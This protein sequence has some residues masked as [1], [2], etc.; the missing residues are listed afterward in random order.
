MYSDKL[1]IYSTDINADTRLYILKSRV[2]RLCRSAI[3]SGHG[4]GVCLVPLCRNPEVPQ[5]GLEV[6]G[7][8]AGT[9]PKKGPESMCLSAASAGHISSLHRPHLTFLLPFLQRAPGAFV[10]IPSK[11]SQH[12]C[13]VGKDSGP[14]RCPLGRGLGSSLPL[15]KPTAA[16]LGEQRYPASRGQSA[17][18]PLRSLLG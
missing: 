7:A 17:H 12:P 16:H 4:V 3:R 15:P 9:G 1:E 8:V 13:E 18:P 14:P 2:H 6:A 5:V 11:V 10:L